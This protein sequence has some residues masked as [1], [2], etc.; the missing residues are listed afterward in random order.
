MKTINILTGFLL[1]YSADA[2]LISKDYSGYDFN[3]VD[4]D[5][6]MEHDDQFYK[7]YYFGQLGN[8]HGNLGPI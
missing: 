7:H 8:D 6:A 1:I 2:I 5:D 3:A 4:L